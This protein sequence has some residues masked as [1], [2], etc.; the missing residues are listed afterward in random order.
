M[1][2]MLVTGSNRG[3]GLEW[4]RQYAAAGWTVHATCRDPDEA[5]ELNA[6]ADDNTRLQVHRLDVTKPEQLAV[7]ARELRD[8]PLDLLVNNA[9]VYFERWG[10]D[11]V[12]SIDYDDWEESFRVNTLGPVRVTE[13]LLDP[14]ARSGKRL[15][16]VISSRMGS[17]AN[18]TDGRNYA[19]R[20]SKA[21][22]NAA[23]HGLAHELSAKG[24]G[25]LLLHPGWVNTRMGGADAPYT[26]QQSVAGMRELV[27]RFEPAWSGRFLKFDGQ[28]LPW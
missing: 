26:P 24:V 21:A 7:V 5:D 18:I 16:V 27:D 15:V 3:L 13:A 12:G 17:I 10:R 4:V 22:V 14:V 19:Y 23:A 6:L 25:L 1:P 28:E 2:T 8:E 9:G 20:S 11:P